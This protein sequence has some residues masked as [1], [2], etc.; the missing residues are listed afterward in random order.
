VFHTVKSQ[1]PKL[2]LVLAGR[3][4]YFYKRLEQLVKIQNVPT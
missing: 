4:D 2:H 3:I 1:F